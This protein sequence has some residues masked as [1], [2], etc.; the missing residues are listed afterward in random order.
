[1]YAH[2]IIEYLSATYQSKLLLFII[3]ITPILLFLV[4]YIIPLL[5]DGTMF[6]SFHIEDRYMLL[7][8]HL[9]PSTKANS[10]S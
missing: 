8:A 7:S 3:L 6:I 2:L 5:S 10:M 9:A 1:M 4:K